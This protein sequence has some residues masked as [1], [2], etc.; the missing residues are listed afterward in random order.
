MPKKI[1]QKELVDLIVDDFRFLHE[2]DK[3]FLSNFNKFLEST[4]KVIMQELKKGNSVNLT[5]FG[6]FETFT[7]YA[8]NANN[9]ATNEIIKIPEV[10][11]AKFRTGSNLKKI[12][13]K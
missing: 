6:K 2:T 10:T 12:L 9:P 3:K 7:R 11:V 8:R 1:N 4:K 5:G 13:K